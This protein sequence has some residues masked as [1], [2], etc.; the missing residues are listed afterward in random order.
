VRPVDKD[1]LGQS[2]PAHLAVARVGGAGVVARRKRLVPAD[3][4]EGD[5]GAVHRHRPGLRIEHLGRA[6]LGLDLP[7]EVAVGDGLRDIRTPGRLVVDHDCLQVLAAPDRSD[8]I[9]HAARAPLVVDHGGRRNEQLAGRADREHAR[10][11]VRGLKQA[12]GLERALA[13]QRRARA[14]S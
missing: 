8:A 9:A 5:R 7:H 14:R 4:F 10:V 2:V 12:R 6:D 11:G 13:P 1:P 3:R